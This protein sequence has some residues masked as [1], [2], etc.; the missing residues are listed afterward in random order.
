MCGWDGEGEWVIGRWR[1]RES[2]EC[3]RENGC[4]EGRMK[5]GESQRKGGK[6]N[7]V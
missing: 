1:Q 3:E 7:I 2:D 6:D 4:E 5:V